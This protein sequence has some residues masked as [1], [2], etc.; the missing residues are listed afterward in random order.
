[1]NRVVAAAAVVT[2]D[3]KS[4]ARYAGVPARRPR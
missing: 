3:R 4:G 2:K 1:M